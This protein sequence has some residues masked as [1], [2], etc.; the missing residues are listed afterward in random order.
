MTKNAKT[1]I[2][3]LLV[4]AVIAIAPI[5]MLGQKA[6]FGG[7]DGAAGDA[8][9]EITGEG[10]EYTPWFNPPIESLFA[11]GLPGELESLLFCLQA[12]LGSGV[13]FY[14]LGVL[15]ERSRQEKR[16]ENQASS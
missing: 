2:V 9:M 5:L 7:A 13:F 16:K 11:D 3:L 4:A 12:A 6:E 15:R 8:I 1:V 14:N 10:E